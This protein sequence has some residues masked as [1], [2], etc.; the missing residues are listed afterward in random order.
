MM[1]LVWLE[2]KK[3][4][5][6]K[7]VWIVF[8]LL[9]CMKIVISIYDNASYPNG[10]DPSIYK[11]YIYRIEGLHST[12][13]LEYIN[14]EINRYDELRN[15]E[16]LYVL[17]YRKGE[18]T[19]EEFRSICNEIDKANIVISTLYHIQAK[20]NYYESM[21][22]EGVYF[23]DLDIDRYL[24]ELNIDYSALL[25]I[26]FITALIF[27]SDYQ[28]KIYV[29]V[30]SSRYG[31]R[32]LLNIRICILAIITIIV[33]CVFQLIEF[34][35]KY[36]TLEIEGLDKPVKSMLSF[37]SCSLDVSVCE[38]FGIMFITR[39]IFL[40]FISMMAVA[41][42]YLSKNAMGIIAA[43][44]LI[45][46]IPEFL[47]HILPEWL[48]FILPTGGF[49]GLRIYNPIK[50]VMGISGDIYAWLC[51]GIITAVAIGL[52]EYVESKALG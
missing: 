14:S 49:N 45:V 11:D 24:T 26:L 12:E 31:G 27:A 41:I 33:S 1:R 28:A 42:S 47:A 25:F 38:M 22:P 17:K 20:G 46:V 7:K 15:S 13:K 10:V 52:I 3:N 50:E 39:M 21:Y 44:L 4:L 35:I 43:S 29:L 2:I 48:F 34:I 8:V 19:V 37:M 30:K 16:D 32:I 5:L 23:Y 40:V 36:N 18:I 51:G 9:I 6:Q